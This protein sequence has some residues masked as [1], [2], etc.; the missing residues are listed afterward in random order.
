MLVTNYAVLSAADLA[1]SQTSAPIN[2]YQ[3]YMYSIQSVITGSPVGSIKLQV[4]NDYNI[5]QTPNGAPTP[6]NW[7][8]VATS[9]TAINGATSIL[10]EDPNTSYAWVRVVYTKTSGTG[11]LSARINT[12]GV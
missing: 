1:S 8:D 2:L 5:P 11:S 7:T 12:R 9:V 6:T 3:V 4:S 10:W